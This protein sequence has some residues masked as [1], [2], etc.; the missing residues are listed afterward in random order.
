[1]LA[2]RALAG[3]AL[4]VGLALVAPAWAQAEVRA[5]QMKMF[6]AV[7]A[8]RTG[9]GLA[10]FRSAPRLHRSA[11]AYARWMLRHD[12]FGHLSGIRASSRYS[13][14]GENLA[15]HTGYAA[16]IRRTVRRWMRSPAHRA[17]ILHRGFR[18]LGAGMARGR[19]GEVRGTTWVLHFG[20]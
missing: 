10:P 15:W 2:R 18:W 17:L 6:R 11:R 20:G 1:M 12:Y 14:L 4:L 16:R 5:S 8:E 9:H 19:L 3:A 13:M 7:N